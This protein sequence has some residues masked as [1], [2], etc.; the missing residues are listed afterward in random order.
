MIQPESLLLALES[1]QYSVRL[2]R[3][4]EST[5]RRIGRMHLRICSESFD[6]GTSGY[7]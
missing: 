3:V 7:G 1:W 6:P 4:L 2:V 5:C